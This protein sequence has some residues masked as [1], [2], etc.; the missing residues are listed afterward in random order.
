MTLHR[1]PAAHIHH[2]AAIRTSVLK[3]GDAVAS[4]GDGNAADADAVLGQ[5]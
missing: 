3:N 5:L 2:L 4:E 1:T